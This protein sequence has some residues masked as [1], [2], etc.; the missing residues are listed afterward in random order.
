MK[1]QR[2]HRGNRTP[3]LQARW[4]VPAPQTSERPKPGG[5]LLCPAEKD[6]VKLIRKTP[7]TAEKEQHQLQDMQRQIS[8]STA[9][10]VHHNSLV[11]FTKTDKH[12]QTSGFFLPGEDVA[13]NAATSLSY[14]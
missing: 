12:P 9:A 2:R 3:C 11:D 8:C 6:L 4:L 5:T 7:E 10:G 14:L 1:T 13:A